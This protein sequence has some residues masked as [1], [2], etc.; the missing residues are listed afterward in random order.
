MTDPS[1]QSDHDHA[2][3]DAGFDGDAAVPARSWRG[4]WQLPAIV[5]SLGLIAL[6]VVVASRRAPDEDWDGAL[7][8]VREFIVAGELDLARDRMQLT[9]EPNLLEATPIQQA[10]FR[11]L[12]ADW[13]SQSQATRGASLAENNRLIDE[14]YRMAVDAGLPLDAERIERWGDAQLGLDELD[15]VRDR[16][17]E[18]EALA[19]SSLGGPEAGIRRNRLLRRLVERSLQQEDLP[20]DAMLAALDRYRDDRLL[21]DRDRAW[22]LSREVDLRLEAG[23]FRP[24]VDRLLLEMRRFEMASADL[25]G[26][27]WGGFYGRLA[28]G[29]ERLGLDDDARHHLEQ[30]F[31]RFE[32]ATPDRGRAELL[33]AHLDMAD[34][35]YEEAMS[36][37]AGIVEEYAG[38]DVELPARL[39]LAEVFGIL[40]QHEQ[41]LDD[42]RA[43]RGRLE[44]LPASRDVT[45]I[46]IA[47]SLANRHDAQLA[48][49]NMA[50]ALAY[51]DVA[52]SFFPT[53][54][55]PADVLLRVANANEMMAG[56]LLDD[57]RERI[58]AL[59]ADT[60][61]P[62][63]P[64]DVAESSIDPAIRAEA[65]ERLVVAA[66]HYLR[67]ARAI[68]AIPGQEENWALSL[69]MAAD[70]LDRAGRIDRAVEVMR[71]YLASR[72]RN[73][74]RRARVT[75][76]L[77]TALESIDETELAIE[78][79]R[80]VIDEYGVLP[81]GTAARPSLARVL[82]R[83]GRDTEA[84][85]VLLAVVDGRGSAL[86]S[87][88]AADYQRALTD[89]GRLYL[90]TGREREAIER[91]DAALLRAPEAPDA[92]AVRHWLAESHRGLA[93]RIDER[94]ESA[95][96]M[97]PSERR[98]RS[99]ARDAHLE[100]AILL[101]DDVVAAWDGRD[102][103]TLD[104]RERSMLRGAHVG[105]AR[106]AYDLGRWDLAARLYD[107]VARRF[108]SE[109]IAMQ[110]L[111]QVVNCYER[112]GDPE[113]AEVAHRNALVRLARI[114]DAA[115]DDPGAL[116]DRGAW[117]QWL[118]DR[119]AGRLATATPDEPG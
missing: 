119:P 25:D 44:R 74:P 4:V 52:E 21:S 73:D 13:I 40:G 45:A 97:R 82:M 35:R 84:E 34:G 104:D 23:Q 42:Y 3:A 69:W 75:L 103:A 32:N 31:A 70:T 96:R 81:Q 86:L 51:A 77:A 10:R 83:A 89:L 36:Q 18:L 110:A 116:M 76:R 65:H 59:T 28:R 87:P 14:Q 68:V 8:E 93:G 92:H 60:N 114:P 17:S 53:G 20:L 30:A 101:F 5:G 95:E 29:Y 98:S 113:R 62:I 33:V 117:E 94:L 118:R 79:Y 100:T 50:T 15:A 57:A 43:L 78:R 54:D 107:R 111:V 85:E 55:V 9:L 64:A 38:V 106:A 67:H 12:A 61:A 108:A 115:F 90:R 102:D 19:S 49:G 24:A 66:D 58:A 1:S 27:I 105:R 46:R 26:D 37:L 7:D 99:A 91:L 39:A 63:V 41:S 88:D 48:A 16:V 47:D 56:A 11:A 71:E 6:S 112:L 2:P 22:A 72:P 80:Q 109:H